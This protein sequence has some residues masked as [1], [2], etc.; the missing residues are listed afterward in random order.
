MK[1]MQRLGDRLGSMPRF[2]GATMIAVAAG[3][4]V[5]AILLGIGVY[6][7]SIS[8]R[9]LPF[10]RTGA[11]AGMITSAAFSLLRV[12]SAGA[13]S[14]SLTR[15]V[16]ASLL[17]VLPLWLR[18]S[19]PEFGMSIYELFISCVLWTIVWIAL[20]QLFGRKERGSDSAIPDTA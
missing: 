9:L 1:P 11:I 7:L 13:R 17:G 6:L 10:Y 19:V 15:S 5:G 20:L 18:L 2:I 16:C 8:D 4:A 3:A 12:W 14:R